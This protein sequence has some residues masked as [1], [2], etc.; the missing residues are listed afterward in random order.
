MTIPLRTP[1]PIVVEVALG[2]RSYD[3]VIGRATLPSLGQRLAALRRE[4]KPRSSRM[5]QSPGI[6]SQRQ[7][8]LLRWAVWASRS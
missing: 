6:I 5:P 7:N 3:I 8:P 1:D 2:A 4:P